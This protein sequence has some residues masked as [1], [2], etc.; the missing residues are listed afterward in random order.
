[1]RVGI[2]GPRTSS[3]AVCLVVLVS[4]VNPILGQDHYR[5]QDIYLAYAAYGSE[6][7]FSDHIGEQEAKHFTI[8]GLQLDKTTIEEAQQYLGASPRV[9]LGGHASPFVCYRSTSPADDTVLTFSF[10]DYG[11]HPRLN[12]YQ[13]IDGTE[14]FKAQTHCGRSTLVSRAL[15][16]QGGVKLGLTREQVQRIWDVPVTFKGNHLLIHFSAYKEGQRDDGTIECDKIYSR[17]IA[18]FTKAGLSWVEVSSFGEQVRI[19]RCTDAE[20][21]GEKQRLRSRK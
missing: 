6:D 20:L 1:M 11:K 15:A 4:T 16:S 5:G 19:G 13:I 3:L 14:R 18:R 8:L 9:H 2:I 7:N 10:E 21:S 17:V 12:G